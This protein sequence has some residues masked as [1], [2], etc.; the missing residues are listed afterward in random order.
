MMLAETK[1]QKALLTRTRKFFPLFRPDV[2]R[3]LLLRPGYHGREFV[4]RQMRHELFV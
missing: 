3:C 1:D 4:P 2:R